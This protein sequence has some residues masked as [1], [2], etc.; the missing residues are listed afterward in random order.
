MKLIIVKKEEDVG[1][2]AAFFVKK[3]VS[4]RNKGRKTVLG[5]ATGKTMIPFYAEL[6][7]M[8]KHKKISLSKVVSFNLDEYYPLSAEDKRS[9]RYFMD[10][11]LFSKVD[12]NEGNINFLNGE[13]KNWKKECK[14]YERKIKKVGGIGLMILGLGRDGHIAFDEPGSG[15]K[16]K[17]RKVKLAK[18]TKEDNKVRFGYALTLGLSN[19]M[20]SRKI[21]LLVFGKQKKEIFSRF[22]ESKVSERIPATLLKKHKNIF[23]I[24]DKEATGK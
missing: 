5:L 4:G 12:F 8:Y 18:I 16:S 3:E 9:F 10:K 20:S 13:A 2:K 17:T 24:A 15:F 23:I 6:V 21:L 19:I 7:K 22:L 11:R 14:K 1:K